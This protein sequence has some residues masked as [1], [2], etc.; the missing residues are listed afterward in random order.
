MRA[1]APTVLP[2]AWAR[3]RL[4]EGASRANLLHIDSGTPRAQLGVGARHGCGWQVDAAGVA[5]VHFELCWDG[6]RLWIGDTQRA[7]GVTIDG[8]P[9]GGWQPVSGRSRIEFGGAVML[10]EGSVPAVSI[11]QAP[12]RN[13]LLRQPSIAV[14]T[15][16]MQAYGAPTPDP[17]AYRVRR[18]LSLPLRTWL[19]ITVTVGALLLVMFMGGDDERA[20]PA[21]AAPA[22]KEE[23]A[24]PAPAR[25]APAPAAS[26]ATHAQAAELLM[27]GRQREA[28]A[29][30]DELVHLRPE[31]PVNAAI[32]KILKRRLAA[33][34]AEG[35]PS[36]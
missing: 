13:L 19:L 34:C 31:E 5:P 12:P 18:A 29:V 15:V 16:V 3:V 7:G 22:V 28:L 14:P 36:C 11:D 30:Y 23:V 24:A 2:A 8:A 26:T 33:R 10:A 20:A 32:V 21:P 4:L 6:R 1:P 25:P 27:A 17:A 35:E 9:L